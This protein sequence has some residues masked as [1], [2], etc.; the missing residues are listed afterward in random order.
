MM[1]EAN[2]TADSGT[3][4]NSRCVNVL[5]LGAKGDGMHDD[6][7]EL[8]YAIYEAAKRHV[9]VVIPAGD[10]KIT[11][12]LHLPSR[13]WVLGASR[14]LTRIMAYGITA[15][16]GAN[17][18]ATTYV[19][20]RDLSVVSDIDRELFSNSA[21]GFDLS[22]FTHSLFQCLRCSKAK[23]GIKLENHEECSH[24]TFENLELES[25]ETA[26]EMG[27][28]PTNNC[29]FYNVTVWAAPLLWPNRGVGIHLAGF[30]NL[31]SGFY[32]LNTGTAG[33]L[34]EAN[35]GNNLIINPYMEGT[36]DVD[37]HIGGRK[38]GPGITTGDGLAQDVGIGN[39][40]IAPHFDGGPKFM[41]GSC[42]CDPLN[43]LQ[44]VD[45]NGLTAKGPKE[46]R[47]SRGCPPEVCTSKAHQ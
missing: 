17:T 11:Q 28:K 21:V 10:Y 6:S 43:Q 8:Q 42:I 39:V 19:T 41:T 3:V 25:C 23:F 45:W 22:D 20:I 5:R 30:G 27:P 24:N 36:S 16:K 18:G 7:P 44:I 14:D 33:V 47:P 31:I 29:R 32:C 37:P 38:Y 9:P 15:F 13:V 2:S 35:C 34:M 4:M 1:C 40:V 12:T 26:I 46:A